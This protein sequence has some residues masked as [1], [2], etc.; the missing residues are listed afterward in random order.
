LFHSHTYLEIE[1]L[2]SFWFS[3]DL[4]RRLTVLQQYFCLKRWWLPT[5]LH[6]VITQIIGFQTLLVWGS[7]DV[8]IMLRIPVFKNSKEYGL[9][10]FKYNYQWTLYISEVFFVLNYMFILDYLYYDCQTQTF[11]VQLFIF[12]TIWLYYK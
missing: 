2:Q 1:T 5:K 10:I 9:A 7:I 8:K 12:Y 4:S 3:Y 6:S 11:D